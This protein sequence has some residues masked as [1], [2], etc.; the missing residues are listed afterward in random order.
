MI[1]VFKGGMFYNVF[2][3]NWRNI[4]RYD[5]MIFFR[6]LFS[7]FLDWRVENFGKI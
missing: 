4:I 3:M 1:I 2:L 5:S 7:N 6:C